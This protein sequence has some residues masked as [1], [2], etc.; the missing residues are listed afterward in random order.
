MTVQDNGRAG[1]NGPEHSRRLQFAMRAL[2]RTAVTLGYQ[3]VDLTYEWAENLPRGI[4][5]ADVIGH[6]DANFLPPRAAE[7]LQ[8]AKQQ[9]MRS[10]ETRRIEL[11]VTIAG[12]LRWFDI[13]IDPDT[14]EDGDAGVIGV[15]STIIDISAQKQREVQLRNLLRE[16]SHRSRNLLAIVLS[17]ASQTARSATTIPGF[18][19]AFSGRL[20]AIARAQDLITDRDWQGALLSDLISRQVALFHKDSGLPVELRGD[21]LMV[22]PNAA[23]YVGLAIHEL[24]ANAVRNGQLAAPDGAIDIAFDLDADQDGKRSIT[25]TW[26]EQLDDG[27][28]AEPIEDLTRKF[29]ESVVPLAVDGAGKLTVDS[30]SIAYTLRI[31]GSHIT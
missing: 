20:Q 3:A 28:D 26:S 12:E 25:V 21:D 24:A 9:V 27:A 18:I 13:W 5:A 30:G 4:D 15:F 6:R 2:G 14:G 23:L 22:S 1:G 11:P 8:V 10:G 17:L 19:S 7:R 29:L 16:V 31:D